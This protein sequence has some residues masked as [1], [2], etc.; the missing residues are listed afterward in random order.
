[1]K[2]LVFGS[3]SVWAL[4]MGALL[5]GCGGGSG[6]SGASPPQV[7]AMSI[8]TPNSS[9]ATIQQL[10]AATALAQ[11][12]GVRGVLVTYTWSSLE[13][14]AGQIDVSRLQ[15]EL[16]YY[17]QKGLE[18]F[19]GIQ[20]INTVKRE[21]PPD[22]E[23]VAFDDPVFIARFH[24]LLD[25]VHGALS[26]GEKYVSIGN[27]VDVYLQ[28]HSAEWL[29]YTNFYE[30]A[31]DQ[32]HAQSPGLLVGVTSTFEGYSTQSSGAVHTLNQQS[33]VVMLTYYPLQGG[34]QVRAPTSPVTDVP[35]MLSLADEKPVVLQEAG[36]PSGALNGSSEAS[37]AAFVTSLLQARRTAG[38]RMPFLSYF[39][40]Y[41]FDATTCSAFGVYYG[42]SDPTFLS[43]LCSLGLRRA[44]G[45]EKLAWAAF[46]D[47]L[48]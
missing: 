29:P 17:H 47:A 13:P 45:T 21:V 35:V 26:G 8:D 1:M 3:T 40:L 6:D 30:D 34:A 23:A 22:L 2:P 12:V 14:S 25:A 46:A 16:A 39:L 42:A 41:D 19:L 38:V 18:I 4:A 44:D 27:E 20:V 7:V 36:Y 33:D 43:F 9:A 5:G 15:S 32:I 10:D 48:H 11:G 24:T 37:E 31:L 28:A